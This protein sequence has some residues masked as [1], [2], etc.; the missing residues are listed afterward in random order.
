MNPENRTPKWSWFQPLSC[1]PPQQGPIGLE[2]RMCKV[3]SRQK[4][5]MKQPLGHCTRGTLRSSPKQDDQNLNLVNS[6]VGHAETAL[7]S[8]TCAVTAQSFRLISW[9]LLDLRHLWAKTGTNTILAAQSLYVSCAFSSHLTS[10]NSISHEIL[11]WR[12]TMKTSLLLPPPSCDLHTGSGT[13]AF[14]WFHQIHRLPMLL[15]PLRHR[16]CL[17]DITG[18]CSIFSLSPL[19]SIFTIYSSHHSHL[20]FCVDI[21]FRTFLDFLFLSSMMVRIAVDQDAHR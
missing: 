8:S 15:H 14:F 13:D 9:I 2:S 5:F 20:R 17:F 12:P 19:L 16:G 7:V 21:L 4:I 3:F 18:A 1:G 11:N 10:P 6:Y